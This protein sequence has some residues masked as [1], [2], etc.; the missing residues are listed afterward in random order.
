MAPSKVKYN[1]NNLETW[2]IRQLKAR[3]TSLH[4]AIYQTECFSSHDMVELQ[5]I[6]AELNRR[7]YSFEES[8]TLSIVKG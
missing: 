2:T 1:E 3:A 8:K 4:G 5:A 7:G 6:E